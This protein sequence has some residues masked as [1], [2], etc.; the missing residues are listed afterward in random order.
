MLIKPA[1][2]HNGVAASFLG[3]QVGGAVKLHTKQEVSMGEVPSWLLTSLW[4]GWLLYQLLVACSVCTG[5]PPKFGWC[6]PF[7]EGWQTRWEGRIISW[8][9]SLPLCKAEVGS[10]PQATSRLS[11]EHLQHSLIEI[12]KGGLP[13]K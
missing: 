5:T 13:E 12:L 9:L 3:L 11:S 10:G 7:V 1:T 8:K 6:V 2:Y 4:E